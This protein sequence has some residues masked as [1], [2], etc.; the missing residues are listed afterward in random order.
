MMNGIAYR[1]TTPFDHNIW[2]LHNMKL[3]IDINNYQHTDD[4]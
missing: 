1:V 2:L 3:F 4:E